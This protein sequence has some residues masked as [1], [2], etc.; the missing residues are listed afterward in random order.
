[1]PQKIS[2]ILA[3]A[4]AQDGTIFPDAKGP[5][6]V[7]KKY[8]KLFNE[9]N[10]QLSKIKGSQASQLK[11]TTKNVRRIINVLCRDVKESAK[12]YTENVNNAQW[13]KDAVSYSSPKSRYFGDTLMT[14]KSRLENEKNGMI[15]MPLL[16]PYLDVQWPPNLPVIPD[17][18][19]P[20]Q[21]MKECV[22]I[23]TDRE[24]DLLLNK[25]FGV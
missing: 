17:N 15:I 7:K 21:I 14:R 19:Y 2:D 20:L 5:L 22:Q 24:N 25:S 18:K 11:T 6:Q 3:F 23:L 13:Y 4:S 8:A 1:M 10:T 16:E 9:I 12:N